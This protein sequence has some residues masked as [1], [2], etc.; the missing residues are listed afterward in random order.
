MG[1]GALKF[2]GKSGVLPVP[3]QIIRKPFR[4]V[5]VKP[6]AN[7]GYAEG[8]Q[9]PKGSSRDMRFPKVIPVSEQINLTARDPAK[10]YTE[11]EISKMP[12]QQQWKVKNSELRRTFL[13]ETYYKDLAAIELNE[14]TES[15][16][17]AKEEAKNKLERQHEESNT[18]KLTMPSLDDMLKEKI[19]RERTEEEKELLHQARELNRI[20]WEKTTKTQS[21]LRLLELYNASSEFAVTEEEVNQL[22]DDAFTEKD[23]YA[24]SYKIMRSLTA[25]AAA[26]AK[27]VEDVLKDA[28]VGKLGGGPSLNALKDAVSGVDDEIV[29][30]AQENYHKSLLEKVDSEEQK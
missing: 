22:V 25:T 3:R 4:P 12:L 26:H 8:I 24:S 20:H 21:A 19:M 11:E 5:T 13:K 18:T 10:K 6:S 28:V 1:K 16:R 9:H 2:G 30:E 14:L 29:R 23:S 7:Q 15:K 17:I 27:G